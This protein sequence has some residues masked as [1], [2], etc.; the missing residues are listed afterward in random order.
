MIS[1]GFTYDHSGGD[2]NCQGHG[3]IKKKD[4]IT[5]TSNNNKKTKY[6]AKH[7]TQKD[8]QFL[9][10]VGGNQVEG[11]IKSYKKGSIFWKREARKHEI[12]M[13]GNVYPHENGCACGGAADALSGLVLSETA[14]TSYYE[15]LMFVDSEGIYCKVNDPYTVGLTD[16]S[17]NKTYSFPQ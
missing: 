6:R 7:Q 11:E 17:E 5:W 9:L 15:E 16:D 13:K 2:A 12:N 10:N 4:E 14:K 8:N 3:D 1:I